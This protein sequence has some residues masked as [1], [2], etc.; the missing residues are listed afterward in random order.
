MNRSQL[1]LLVMSIT[2]AIGC[3]GDWTPRIAWPKPRPNVPEP[4]LG[5]D[6]CP[7]GPHVDAQA[8][9]GCMRAR[10][11]AWKTFISTNA[12]HREATV[13][14][15]VMIRALQSCCSIQSS[16]DLR[17]AC[18]MHVQERH[19]QTKVAEGGPPYYIGPSDAVVEVSYPDVPVYNVVDDE[20]CH[21]RSMNR[22]RP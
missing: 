2:I 12:N 22:S 20:I 5:A 4:L 11:E 6:P 21:T 19:V 3:S 9:A 14:A 15:P 16:L 18:I 17:H 8:L 13:G 1:F 7:D 10:D